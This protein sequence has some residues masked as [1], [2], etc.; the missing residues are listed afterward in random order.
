MTIT[1]I[2][3]TT[4]AKA[5]ELF[6]KLAGTSGGAVKTREKLFAELKKELE[7]HA[8]LEE[9]HLFPVLRKHKETKDL[10]ADAVNDNRQTR[11][12]LAELERMPK[13][14]EDF[15]RKLTELRRIFQQ[16]VRD[17]KKE[18]LPAV[19]KAL[20]D[21]ESEAVAG[22][23]EAGR[24]RVEAHR[25]REEAEAMER[26][27]RQPAA[28]LTRPVETLVEG[29]TR[30]AD[31]LGQAAQPALERLEAFSVFPNVAARAINE[32]GEIW[33]EWASRTTQSTANAAQELRLCTSPQELA[34]VQGRIVQEALQAWLDAGTRLMQI[35]IRASEEMMKSGRR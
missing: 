26:R 22:R 15:P 13:D 30:A 28:A 10:I 3:Q 32:A 17:E 31:L 24:A 16:H 18:L 23:I 7:L 5:N 6:G 1:Q 12:L 33:M 8:L 35:P 14:G 25:E 4:P 2:I 34:V 9:Q 29:S 20:S 21:E 19:R 27:T 11:A